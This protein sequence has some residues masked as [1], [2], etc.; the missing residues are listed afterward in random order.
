MEARIEALL[1]EAEKNQAEAQK[2]K[3][4]EAGAALEQEPGKGD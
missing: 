4:A 3:D 2:L 1:A